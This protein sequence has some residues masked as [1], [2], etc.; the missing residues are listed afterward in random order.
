MAKDQR[1]PISRAQMAHQQQEWG[2]EALEISIDLACP[3]SDKY[4]MT[5]NILQHQILNQAKRNDVKSDSMFF[6]MPK[7]PE[8]L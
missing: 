6:L 5:D 8:K 4:G 3:Q 1:S 7:W 2:R